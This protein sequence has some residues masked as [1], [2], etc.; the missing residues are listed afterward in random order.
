MTNVHESLT[1][2]VPITFSFTTFVL[3]IVLIVLVL[4]Y[5]LGE[6]DDD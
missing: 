1:G 6:L 5:A 4:L 3:I 2:R